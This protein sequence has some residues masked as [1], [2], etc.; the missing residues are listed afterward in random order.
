MVPWPCFHM[1]VIYP[2]LY[3][4]NQPNHPTSF[5]TAEIPCFVRREN[6]NLIMR[7]M[8][9]MTLQEKSHC[10]V[11]KTISRCPKIYSTETQTSPSVASPQSNQNWPFSRPTN[12]RTYIMTHTSS[13]GNSPK[14]TKFQQQKKT[15][16]PLV[17]VYSLLLKMATEIVD[18]PS[19]KRDFP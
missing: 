6:H 16:N 4:T 14:I 2:S 12:E 18:V 8:H 5:R 13:R 9:G 15:T 7:T 17:N 19:K 1:F 11:R 3:V 10:R